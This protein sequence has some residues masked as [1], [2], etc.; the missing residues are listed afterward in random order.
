MLSPAN[1]DL[2]SR[3]S[4]LPGLATLLEPEAFLARLR[5]AF[6][7]AEIAHVRP[8]YIRYKPATN[9]LV[10]YQVDI[11]GQTVQVHA[12]AFGEGAPVK[13]KKAQLKASAPG[14][15]GA[16]Y[17]VLED[18]GAV[19]YAFPNDPDL[20]ALREL[21]DTSSRERLL[22]RL[23]KDRPELWSGTLHDLQYKPGRRYVA[24]LDTENGAQA[25]LKFYASAEFAAANAV[26][27]ARLKSAGQLSLP[28]VC[29]RSNG[30]HVLAFKWLPGIPLHDLVQNSGLNPAILGRIG[31]ALANLHG[32]KAKRLAKRTR[33]AEVARMRQ[34]A[35]AIEILCPNLTAQAGR[36][37][38]RISSQLAQADARHQPVHGDFNDRQILLSEDAVAI[39]DL[40][41]AVAGDPAYDLGLFIAHL[42]RYAVAGELDPGQ[43]ERLTESFLHGYDQAREKGVPSRIDLYTAFGLMQLAT[44]PFRTQA[45]DWPSQIETMLA[46]AEALLS[47][48]ATGSTGRPA[49]LVREG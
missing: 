16:G 11:G 46:H 29:G 44:E 23:L 30:K 1:A 31:A 33:A 20:K 25:V 43:V 32:Q 21:G 49:A 9:C 35:D 48:N 27:R 15:L 24:R 26:T 12:R 22:R 10:L 19:V 3:D 38:E 14:T 2:V 6:P 8:S 4:A 7:D 18:I 39:L 34:Q 37:A 36:I 5:L 13:L 40:D 42:D 41:E 45:P 28:P 47:Q 17:A